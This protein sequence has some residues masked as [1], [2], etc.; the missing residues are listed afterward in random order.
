L[1]AKTDVP[2]GEVDVDKNKKNKKDK[3]DGKVRWQ[4]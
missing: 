2:V 1:R 4:A 3:L